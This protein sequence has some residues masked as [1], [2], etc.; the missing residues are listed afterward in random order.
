MVID[1]FPADA[2]ARGGHSTFLRGRV[3]KWHVPIGHIDYLSAAG[4]NRC[5]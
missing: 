4:N 5:Q 2:W 3:Q 1:G